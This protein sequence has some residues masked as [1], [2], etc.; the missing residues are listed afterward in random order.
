MTAFA[1][2]SLVRARGREWLVLPDSDDDLLVLRPLGG[3]EDDTAGVLPTLES[4]EAA[5]FPPP[6]PPDLGDSASG[7]LLRT[8]LQIGFRSSAG[9]F[10][11]LARLA[12]EPRAYQYVPLMLA[13]RQDPVR[14]LIADDV[15]VGKTIEAAL[16]AAELIAQGDVER[17]AV[18]C[19]PALAEQ[20]QRELR[21]KFSLDA[22]TVL[23]STAAR[24]GRGLLLDESLFDRYPY[25]VI[26]TD[27]IKSPQRRQEFLT[28]RSWS[29]ST[30]R[31]P[32]WPTALPG[33]APRPARSA[34]TSS[35]R[36]RPIPA[37][38][39]C[40]PPP[41]PTPARSRASGTW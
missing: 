19:S 22:E 34:T 33:A 28:A 16:I 13:L 29:S 38:T 14:I 36:S 3:S 26:S 2:G 15:G 21:Q 1:P 12:V 11:S 6:G 17:L 25:T 40:W 31:T 8:A 27:F 32:A 20:W 4:V 30:K 37:A 5:T 23:P 24:L 41:P 7:R 35:N 9:P 18:L 10:R 39:S